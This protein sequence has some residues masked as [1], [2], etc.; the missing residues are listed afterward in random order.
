M[1]QF[2]WHRHFEDA[3]TQPLPAVNHGF[4]SGPQARDAH[5]PW[6]IELPMERTE[7]VEIIQQLE[8]EHKHP[9][10]WYLAGLG[11]FTIVVLIVALLVTLFLW[12]VG[13]IT[14]PVF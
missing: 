7:A 14:G 13:V 11:T 9:L 3:D 8:W 4:S 6:L 1:S 12:V 2:K 5:L 10:R